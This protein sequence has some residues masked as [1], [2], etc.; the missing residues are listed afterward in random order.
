MD[1]QKIRVVHYVN[2]FFGQEGGEEKADMSF[3]V[4]KGPVGPGI[5]L[6][7]ILDDRAKIVATLICGDNYF[8]ENVA[9]ASE[10]GL[11]MVLP[12]RPDLFIAGPAFEAG[13][14]G[15]ACGAICKV[16]QER[17]RIPA[18][19]G[20]YEENPGVDLY[21]RYL[22]IC[23]TEHSAVKMIDNLKSM[24]HLAF[25]LLTV[26]KAS[27]LV[28]GERIGTPFEAGYFPRGILKN[29]YTEKTAAERALDMMIAKVLKKDFQ[30][31]VMIPDFEEIPPPPPI[32]DANSCEIALI[33]DGGLV[34]KGNPHR[35]SGRGNQ[36]LAMYEVD[37]Y[38]PKKGK[39]SEHEIA[40][41]GYFPNEV[42]EDFNR[43]VPVE[44]L[45]DLEEEGVIRKLHPIF[46]STSGNGTSS[47]RCREMGEEI[48]MELKKRGVDAAILTS[49]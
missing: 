2:Q 17:L 34:P 31:E 29:G 16:I 3:L 20:M 6:Q 15:I 28:S 39:D 4:K 38:F 21:R 1:Q 19:T 13:R 42:L 41:T 7:N 12:Y 44:I 27:N 10:E 24:V 43:L 9:K 18:I 45:R 47:K 8:A 37:Q 46:Y 35:F 48:G 14:Y 25:Q 32:K 11:K 40:H 5:A 22:Y 36:A 30:S 49:T 26:D 23:K 33:S